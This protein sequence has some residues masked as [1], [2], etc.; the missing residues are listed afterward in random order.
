MCLSVEQQT[1]SAKDIQNDKG[2][3]K[4]YKTYRQIQNGL[5]YACI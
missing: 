3:T 5:A 1:I 2:A 4:Y